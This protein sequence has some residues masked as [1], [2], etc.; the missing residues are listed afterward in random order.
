MDITKRHYDSAAWALPKDITPLQHGLYHCHRCYQKSSKPLLGSPIVSS[1]KCASL[2]QL[3]SFLFSS[4]WMS[5]YT[6]VKE[7]HFNTGIKPEPVHTLMLP[8]MAPRCLLR[9]SVRDPEGIAALLQKPSLRAN[10]R[11]HIQMDVWWVFVFR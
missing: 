5:A 6:H 10:S 7:L 8:L 4:S 2:P 1:E 9:C 11:H 3:S